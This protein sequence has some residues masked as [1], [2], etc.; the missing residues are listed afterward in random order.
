MG[1]AVADEGQDL[2]QFPADSH[3][4]RIVMWRQ[5]AQSFINWVSPLLAGTLTLERVVVDM[6]H[7]TDSGTAQ[8]IAG[9][10]FALLLQHNAYGVAGEPSQEVLLKKGAQLL[11]KRLRDWYALPGQ[12]RVSC[13]DFLTVGVLIGAGGLGR[14]CCKGKALE[15][16]GLFKFARHELDLHQHFLQ[17]VS[18]AVGFQA[19]LLS[20]A[21]SHLAAY[22]RILQENGPLLPAETSQRLTAA[23]AATCTYYKAAGFAPA[24]KF[25]LQWETASESQYSGNPRHFAC[26]VD[27]DFN[28]IVAG[29][30]KRVHARTFTQSVLKKL[31]I[32]RMCRDAT[33]QPVALP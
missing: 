1:G 23:A 25:H 22:Y 32:L 11:D 12:A 14:P 15:S 16:R 9:S 2:T 10:I 4:V 24:P 29:V 6:L 26:Y 13:V 7:T 33:Q 31:R 5:P 8:Y 3:P 21:A 20:D 17:G 30:A 18:P 28:Q 19:R 27:E